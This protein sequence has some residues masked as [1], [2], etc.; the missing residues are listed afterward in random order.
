MS[1]LTRP[2]SRRC[3]PALRHTICG[4]LVAT[5]FSSC[6]LIIDSD[7]YVGTGSSCA[8]CAGFCANPGTDAETCCDA[9]GDGFAPA[10]A[11][12]DCGPVTDIDCD[13]NAASVFPGAPAI[14]GDGLRNDCNAPAVP[15]FLGGTTFVEHSVTDPILVTATI[16]I[17]GLPVL[18]VVAL[19]S[20]PSAA[21]DT[22]NLMVS[23]QDPGNNAAGLFFYSDALGGVTAEALLDVAAAGLPRSAIA[24]ASLALVN[25]DIVLAIRRTDP[26]GDIELYSLPLTGLDT[27]GVEPV[28]L[29]SATRT[30]VTTDTRINNSPVVQ[31]AEQVSPTRSSPVA[32]FPIPNGMCRLPNSDGPGACLSD[33]AIWASPGYTRTAQGFS[34]DAS[35]SSFLN[36]GSDVSQTLILNDGSEAREFGIPRPVTT[37]PIDI[38]GVWGA[39]MFGSQVA[40]GV[41]ILSVND[42]LGWL[43]LLRI[44]CTG[45]AT[46]SCSLSSSTVLRNDL[47]SIAE[48][49]VARLAPY[50][51]GLLVVT[52]GRSGVGAPPIVIQTVE[53]NGPATV[54]VLDGLLSFS[55]AADYNRIPELET[56]VHEGPRGTS[57]GVAFT[58]EGGAEEVS[59]WVAGAQ[60]CNVL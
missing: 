39:T 8:S 17:G 7:Q 21:G 45:P 42:N 52:A 47:R 30:A 56:S 51:E 1:F 18:D 36:H 25:E 32:V 59:S 16:G 35:Q 37:D 12:A 24:G 3:L 4:L 29:A 40:V 6:S 15:T 28:V 31:I 57:I 38:T 33:R 55:P 44:N 43:R 50:R 19:P 2:L 20:D 48:S 5:A 9:D 49:S 60:L 34:I 27:T 41:P 26:P 46:S 13:D 10:T 54:Q 58:T 23:A 22:L 14:C 11:S 53:R